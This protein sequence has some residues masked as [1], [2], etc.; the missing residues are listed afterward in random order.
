MNMTETTQK[1]LDFCQANHPDLRW[2]DDSWTG[3]NGEP[4]IYGCKA[5]FVGLGITTIKIYIDIISHNSNN[6][7]V[8]LIKGYSTIDHL[9]WEGVFTVWVNQKKNNEILFKGDGICQCKELNLW[10]EKG[11]QVMI[12]IFEFIETEIQTEVTLCQ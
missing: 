8:N 7:Q 6:L 1:I 9:A 10:R 12:D 5:F 4:C 3:Q 11:T 2:D